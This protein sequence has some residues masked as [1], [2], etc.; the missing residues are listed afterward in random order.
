MEAFLA[1]VKRERAGK[2]TEEDAKDDSL[3]NLEAVTGQLGFEELKE[4]T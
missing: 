4:H 1:R 3:P 2:Q